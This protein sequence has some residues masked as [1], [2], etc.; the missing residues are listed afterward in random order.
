[1]TTSDAVDDRFYA[2]LLASE[3]IKRAQAPT[4]ATALVVI[5]AAG[6][7]CA[8][9]AQV[10]RYLSRIDPRPAPSEGHIQ[11]VMAAFLGA[12]V[13]HDLDPAA[14]I[15]A[16]FATRASCAIDDWTDALNDINAAA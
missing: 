12:C 2:G 1:M 4:L 15:A 10:R 6:A 11:Q 16:G 7:A 13:E 8:A 3:A 14:V 9:H 5:P